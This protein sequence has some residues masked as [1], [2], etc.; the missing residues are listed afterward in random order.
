VI[1]DLRT[2]RHGQQPNERIS[3]G[4]PGEDSL[5][6]LVPRVSGATDV[7]RKSASNEP[8]QNLINAYGELPMSFEVNVGQA[9]NQVKFL[10]RGS[11]YS[12]FL[13]S[14]EAVL[15]LNRNVRK[16]GNAIAEQMVGPQARNP[17]HDAAGIGERVRQDVLRLR[18]VGANPAAKIEGSD[19]LPGKSN[20]FVGND[21]AKWHSDISTYANVKYES[22]YSGINAVYYGNQGQLEYDLVIAPHADYKQIRLKYEGAKR[23]RIGETSGDL[24]L[25]TRDGSHLRQHKPVI[26]QEIAG[27]RRLV[28]GSYEFRANREIGFRIGEYDASVALVIDPTLAYST[29]LGGSG[30]D[31]AIGIAVDSSGSV[32]VCG[33]TSSTNFPTANAL[34]PTFGG[35]SPVSNSDVFITKLNSSG[36]AL[37]YST[38]LGGA[39]DDFGSGVA[40]DSS[41]S[42]YV[43][44]GTFSFNFP[45]SNAIQPN[46][47]GALDGFIAKLSSG[48]NQLVYSTYLGGSD[49]DRGYR[50]AV[51]SSGNGYVT[52]FTDSTNF[53]TANSAQPTYA[54]GEDAF[55]TKLN[56]AGTQLVYS[57]YLGGSN[58][59]D[60]NS[61]AVDSSGNAYTVGS[62]SST[63][64]PTFNAMQ[65]ANTSGGCC[66]AFVTKLNAAGAYV[67]ST[68]L[69]GNGYDQATGVAVDSSGDTYVCGTTG[70]GFPTVNA[71]QSAFG[72]SVFDAFIAKLNPTGSALIFS[73]YLGGINNDQGLRIALDP[74][75][76]AYV[77][78]STSSTNFPTT[79][80]F[81]PSLGG[82][83]NGDGFVAELSST[84]GQLAYSSYLGG[85][86]DDVAIGIAVDSSG[87][88]YV[89][90]NTQS[91][92]F[93]TVNAFQATYMGG[94]AGSNGSI[95]D[96]FVTKILAAPS[97]TPIVIQFSAETYTVNEGIASAIVPVNRTGDISAAATVDYATSDTSGANN[98]NVISH[99]ASSR[100]DY[101]TTIGTLHF[102][103][104]EVSKDISILII[105]DAY[106]EGN[107]NFTITLTNPSGATL[108][109]TTTATTTINDN[110]TVNGTNPIDTASFFVRQHYLD[111]LNRQPDS[112][113]LAFWTNEITSCG[114]NQSCIDVKRINV[115]AAFY[116]SIEFQGTGYLV[117][118]I[119]KVAYGDATRSSTFNGFHVF[120][121]PIVRLNEFLPDTQEVGNGVI[122]GQS[123]WEQV[124]ENNKQAFTTEFVQRS[125]FITAFPSTMTPAQ[126]VDKL[127]ANTGNPLS[128]TERNQLISDLSTNAKT[129]AQVLRAVAED[130]DLNNAEFN[131]AFVLMQY[132]GYLR[133]NPNDPQDTDYTGYDFWLTK[134]NQFNGNFQNA[135]MVKAFITSGE[136]RQR[137]GP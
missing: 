137:F 70:G 68:Y 27:E 95:G 51:D 16:A 92:N 50:I 82:G 100:C 40:L 37:I 18:L 110:E 48:G 46:T 20:Y 44:G 126:F 58:L 3:T 119:Y 79:N 11:G 97:P 91:T 26:Y 103:P 33:S 107:E 117:E 31:S 102:A 42:A 38:Y 87:N 63:N 96:A 2:R 78:G 127:N 130:A 65:A 23:V 1:V 104:N 30:G 85:N 28:E 9:D 115:S 45:V 94:Q 19:K 88:A 54:G 34:Q 21:S 132:F 76:N 136:Y 49:F 109:S 15:A 77:V 39:S 64:F 123:G 75:G 24:I 32:Y 72:G 111:F 125:R 61:I 90:G 62:T 69:G 57:T 52:G 83:P 7:I 59:D 108:G 128:Q 53:P 105:D 93:P 10:S 114:S 99:V 101:L 89:T 43:T 121:V 41:G 56:S 74:A 5:A 36:N 124:L 6:D 60:G 131:R 55:V 129:R 135:E 47:G 84:G 14:T 8:R 22:V 116:L 12:L 73:T 25:T 122:V 29:Y 120:P 71:F 98:C 106:A 13:T 81:Q 134:L 4:Q 17:K 66:D 118:R 35:G 113:G 80:A 112:S 67:Y 133:R 86:A